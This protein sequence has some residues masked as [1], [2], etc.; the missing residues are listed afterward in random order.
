MKFGDT[1]YQRSIPKWAAYNV[2]YNEIKRL[3]KIRTTAGIAAPISIPG[4]GTHRWTELEN[5]MFHTLKQQHDNVSLFLRTKHGEIDRRIVHLEKQSKSA[6]RTCE[7]PNSRQVL[8]GR[9]YH[10]LLQEAEA[11]GEDIQ[12]LSRFASVQKT[13]FRKLLK[14]YRKWTNSTGLQTRLEDD[15][16]SAGELNLDY[17]RQLERLAVQT[18]IIT[19]TLQGPMLRGENAPETKTNRTES[20][21]PASATSVAKINEALSSGP[22]KFDAAFA[23][24]PF[25]Q[26]SGSAIYWIHPDNLDEARV[27]LL[28][29]VPEVT[30]T[31]RASRQNS[32]ASM[33]SQHSN[34]LSH[35]SANEG[36]HVVYY[37]NLQRFVQ[38]RSLARPSRIALS[39]RWCESSDAV[40][41][42]FNLAPSGSG[43]TGEIVQLKRKELSA[44]LSRSTTSGQRNSRPKDSSSNVKSVQEYLLEHRDVK[45][46]AE[47]HSRRSRHCSIPNSSKVGTWATLDADLVITPFDVDRLGA[48]DADVETGEAFPHAVLEIR[49]E[50][51]HVPEVV[52]AF[53]TSH[54]AERVKDFSLEAAAVYTMQEDLSPPSWRP[55]LGKDIR[56]V[57]ITSRA[58]RRLAHASRASIAGTAS[59]TSS[60][61]GPTESVFSPNPGQSSATSE[62]SLNASLAELASPNVSKPKLAI[63]GRRKKKARISAQSP[64]RAPTRYWNEFDDGDEDVNPDEGYA[65]YVDPDARFPGTE[66]IAKVFGA[67]YQ[68]CSN[69]KSKM[70]SWSPLITRRHS[71]KTNS[72]RTPL[73]ITTDLDN[74]SSDSD[75]TPVPSFPG[76]PTR[77]GVKKSRKSSSLKS[78]VAS[79]RPQQQVSRRR[80][81]LERTYFQ[82]YTGLLILSYVFLFIS[83][84]LLGAG[85]RK[86]KVE[87]DVGIVVGIAS[88][89]VCAIISIALVWMRRMPIGVVHWGIVCVSVSGIVIVGAG[90]LAAVVTK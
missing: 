9:R 85:R 37:D 48:V 11:I 36:T 18:T 90:L 57:P 52:R 24:V 8:Q 64:Q 63:N 38:D 60:T 5:D 79:Y 70:I 87:V 12:A 51:G 15:V 22:L 21:L 84:I 34:D 25:G 50:F 54:L 46:L 43:S 49:W 1:L 30:T 2:N 71:E 66:T 88:A 17:A 20:G 35:Y 33:N 6:R 55:L 69:A 78:K 86:A 76:S 3:I 73:L 65:I 4:Q 72:E 40:V 16:F 27:L 39:G 14:K 19:E 83:A 32:V 23:T 77:F 82:V 53:D 75:S 29:H 7:S 56:N 47:M 44:A 59:G 80:M 13:A 31:L 81:M 10:K 58:S 45:P 89:E 62:G 68:S 26:S 28:R 42:L 41:T 74:E 67:V 61:D